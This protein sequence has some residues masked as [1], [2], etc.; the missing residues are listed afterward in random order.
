[1]DKGKGKA[2]KFGAA[3]AAAGLEPPPGATQHLHAISSAAQAEQM[4]EANNAN[5]EAH[6]LASARQWAAAEAA[7]DRALALKAALYPPD[8]VAH[9]ISLSGRADMYLE[10]GR[11]GGGGAPKLAASAADAARM[12]GIASRIRSPQQLRIAREIG[13]DVARAQAALAAKAAAK[14]SPSAP[15]PPPPPPMRVRDT[16]SDTLVPTDLAPSPLRGGGVTLT[17]EGPTR[18]CERVGCGATTAALD[19]GDLLRC[20]RCH[21][22]YYCSPGC[23]R[24]DWK[25]HKTS[26]APG[27]SG[28]KS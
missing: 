19:G 21:R 9:C 17:R 15:P 2:H 5:N 25:E 20:G 28:G 4:L 1:M 22:R 13:D 10:W 8:D 11:S 12:L 23:Q 7:F 26:C 24:A 16:A 27:G 14:S 18:V 6:R 3:A